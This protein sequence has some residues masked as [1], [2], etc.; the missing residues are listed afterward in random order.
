MQTVILLI[1]V[2]P[3]KTELIGIC[4]ILGFLGYWTAGRVCKSGSQ[5]KDKIHAVVKRFH[6]LLGGCCIIGEVQVAVT[7]KAHF[8]VVPKEAVCMEAITKLHTV[9]GTLVFLFV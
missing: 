1:K 2:D 4:P 8:G 6:I 3:I 9:V 5:A 7:D